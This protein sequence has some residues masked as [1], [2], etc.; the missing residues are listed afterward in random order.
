MVHQYRPKPPA[1]LAYASNIGD[2]V[3]K[4]GRGFAHTVGQ[5]K[6]TGAAQ[7]AGA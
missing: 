5:R 7:G 1:M 2:A 6:V 3:L 4:P